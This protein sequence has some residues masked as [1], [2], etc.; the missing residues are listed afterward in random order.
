MSIVVVG[1]VFFDSIETPHGKVDRALGGAATYF[2]V[3]ASFFTPV[4]MVATVGEDFPEEERSFLQSRRIDLSGLEIQTGLTGSWSGRYHEDMNQRDTL[5]LQL[6]VFA[7]FRP[8]LPSSYRDAQYV[9][10][11]NI[12]PKLQSLVLDQLSAP[13]VIGCD[14]MNYWISNAR[15]DLEQLLGRVGLLVINDEEA[16]QL[17]GERNIVRAARKLL[18][19]GPKRVLIKRGEYG[20]IQFSSDSIFAVPAFPLEEVFDPTGAG[21][22]FAGGLMGE[23]A[24]SGDVSEAGLRRAIVCGSVLASFVVEDFGMRRL[25]KLTREE[26]DRR[27]RQFVSLT[28]I[29]AR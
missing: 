21:D 1:S 26:V 17:S 7:D 22:T 24:R 29:E 5:D 19:M 4:K 27:Y 13:G 23:L 12:D 6:N 18:E 10:L 8:R 25:K 20:V 16:R 2:S 11:A 15:G 14:T 3:A 9:F 28:D